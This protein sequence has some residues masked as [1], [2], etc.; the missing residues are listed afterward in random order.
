MKLK[1]K[2]IRQWLMKIGLY[3]QIN[4]MYE[5]KLEFH[6]WNNFIEITFY[7]YD[8]SFRKYRNEASTSVESFIFVTWCKPHR[9]APPLTSFFLDSNQMLLTSVY[10]MLLQFKYF[11]LNE[12]IRLQGLCFNYSSIICKLYFSYLHYA[13]EHT[14]LIKNLTQLMKKQNIWMWTIK[15]IIESCMKWFN[16][17]IFLNNLFYYK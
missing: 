13:F 17:I 12:F 1:S 15:W 10:N 8:L 14:N 6:D 3:I 2:L 11:V 9:F 5:I 7:C 16:C 4:P